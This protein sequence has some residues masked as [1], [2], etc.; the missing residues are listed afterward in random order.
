MSL[1]YRNPLL[2]FTDRS[3]I[4]LSR[5]GPRLAPPLAITRR[6]RCEL[7]GHRHHVAEPP[8]DFRALRSD[9]SDAGLSQYA[10]ACFTPSFSF[11][12]QPGFWERRFAR[13]PEP[14]PPRSSTAFLCR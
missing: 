12:I 9:R 7:R 13:G 4:E 1:F 6:L 14:G 5:F 10:P 8:F 11:P 3:A 2:V